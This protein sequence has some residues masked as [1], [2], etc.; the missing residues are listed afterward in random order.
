MNED[1]LQKLFNFLSKENKY[2][3]KT[4]V[5]ALSIYSTGIGKGFIKMDRDELQRAERLL[6][7]ARKLL[8]E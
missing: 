1:V 5:N 7:L 6:G 4:I 8:D 2:D 3:I